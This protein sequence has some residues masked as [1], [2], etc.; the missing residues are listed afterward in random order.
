MTD[1]A[2]LGLKIEF[3]QVDQARDSLNKFTASAKATQAATVKMSGEM[4]KA[5]NSVGQINQR[6]NVKDSFGGAQRAADIAAYGNELNNLRARFVPLYAAERAHKTA[7]DEISQAAKVGAISEAERANAVRMA[8]TAYLRNY[9]NEGQR[10]RAQG[11][12]SAGGA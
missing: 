2:S 12:R 11:H 8:E 9:R 5:V 1:V 6:L 3:Q 7:I 10:K 4:Q